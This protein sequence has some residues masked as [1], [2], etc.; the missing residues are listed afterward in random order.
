MSD[1]IQIEVQKKHDPWKNQ[2]RFTPRPLL[3]KQIMDMHDGDGPISE[4][5]NYIIQAGIASIKGTKS[6]HHY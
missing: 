5:I 2:M 3:K 6:K 1:F 4:T